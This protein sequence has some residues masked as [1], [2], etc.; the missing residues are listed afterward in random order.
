MENDL[1]IEHFSPGI[2]ELT[3]LAVEAK[4]ITLPDLFDKDQLKKV[5]E[6]RLELGRARVN[7]TKVGKALR[8]T[9]LK[10]QRDVIAK[11]K[12]FIA[13]VEPEEIRLKGLEDASEK[14]EDRKA[15]L[16]LLPARMTQIESI[17]DGLPFPVDE[18][19]LD[20]DANTFMGYLNKRLADKNE[21]DRQKLTADQ[22][23]LDDEKGELQRKKDIVEAEERGR[24]AAAEKSEQDKKDDEA[25]K[26]KAKEDAERAEAEE[27]ARLESQNLYKEFRRIHG[28]TE[29]TKADYKEENNGEEVILWKKIG[30]FKIK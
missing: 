12:E 17:A 18:V 27:K 6:T 9:A 20:M 23:K 24:K 30:T 21:A 16:E 26:V 29:E 14:A 25:R 15:R 11:E 1:N 19:L 5:K 8:E 4:S 7:I 3:K 13:L 10:F 2:A 22:K 28:W